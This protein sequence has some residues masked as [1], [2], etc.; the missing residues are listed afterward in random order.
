[1]SG[2]IHTQAV[3]PREISPSQ[4]LLDRLSGLQSWSG[5]SREEAKT[6]RCPCRES[7]PGRP[8]HGLVRSQ[9]VYKH[10][11]RGAKIS[12]CSNLAT[13]WTTVV[14]FPAET[15]KTIFLFVAAPRPALRSTQLPNRWVL[16]ALSTGWSGRCV[17]LTT[18]H[19]LFPR[20]GMRG[21]TSPLPNTPSWRKLNTGTILSFARNSS[22]QTFNKLENV[23][24][25]RPKEN[26]VFSV[27]KTDLFPSV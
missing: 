17:R 7:K 1:V 9:W 16:G 20:L 11:Y 4:Y 22:R 6:L 27:L 5:H 13:D 3:R 18:H 23:P 21:V 19:S 25:S 12:Q 24:S 2:Q 26:T 10:F 15:V 14:H 8:T